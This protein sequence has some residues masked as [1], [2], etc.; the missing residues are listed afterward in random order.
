M[1]KLVTYDPGQFRY[2]VLF[3]E[4][5]VSSDNSGGQLP[6]N[7]PVLYTF[8]VRE[9]IR[10]GATLAVTAG[11]TNLNRDCVFVIRHRISFYPR[12]DMTVTAAGETYTIVGVYEINEPVTYLKVVCKRVL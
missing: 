12:V 9:K 10:E 6:N 8:A 5:Q 4:Q 3:T 1:S 11:L 2:K 7:V